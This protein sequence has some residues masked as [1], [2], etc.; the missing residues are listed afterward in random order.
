MNSAYDVVGLAPNKDFG[1]VPIME[2]WFNPTYTDQQ[3]NNLVSNLDKQY[4][5]YEAL[6]SREFNSREAQKQR[7]F[8]ERMSNTAYQRMVADAK[9]AGLNPYL[10]YQQGGAS[11]P[12][13]ATASSS[14]ANSSSGKGIFAR[15]GALGDMVNSAVSLAT[16]YLGRSSGNV[17]KG[18]LGFGATLRY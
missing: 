12:A 5:A 16:A 2:S 10:A 17:G 3:Y 6:K 13:G 9:A 18:G 7:D 4:N 8:E 1:T 11:T 14:G 15:P